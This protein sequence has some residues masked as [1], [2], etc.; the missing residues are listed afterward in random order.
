MGRT[1]VKRPHDSLPRKPRGTSAPAVADTEHLAVLE[2]L[3]LP[4]SLVNRRYTYTWVNT[5]YAGAH[6]KKPEEIIGRTARTLWGDT[7]DKTI[8]DKLDQC[9]AG[10]EARDEGWMHFPTF[11][12]RYCEV[13]YSPYRAP[14]KSV[15]SAIVITYDVTD[16]KELEERLKQREQLAIEQIFMQRD[17]ALRLAQLESFDE[18]LT[19]ILQTALKVAAMESGGIW[20]KKK[21]TGD[22]EL[23]S[24]I[25]PPEELALKSDRL[26]AGSAVWSLVMQGKSVYKPLARQGS[27]TYGAIIP[28]L[29]DG[30]V[31]GSLTM[32][33]PNRKE[34][35]EQGRLTLDFL[36]AE[37]GTIIARMQTRQQLEEEIVTR[38]QAECALEAE[39]LDLQE[40][41]AALRVLLKHREEDRKELE[42]RLVANV[43]QLV[44]PHVEKLKK[45][46][47][48]AS[49][50]TAVGFIEA[51]LKEILSPFLDN[52][53]AFNLTPRQLE[54]IGLIK[55]GRTTKDI[56]EMLHVTKEAI[57]K[58]RFLIRKKLNLNNEKTNLRSYLLSLV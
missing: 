43:K 48:E 38:R 42:S 2:A 30:Q 3:R 27:S 22:L 45:G 52:L 58:Q 40:A 5:R 9:F 11:G 1:S 25:S 35:P 16:R 8:K 13:V 32:A 50:V 7:F 24:S 49:H 31:I 15:S 18:G 26:P 28:I 54:I 33:S 46:R 36:S 41:N 44:L 14:G 4:V 12:R 6:G 10:K 37:L 53:R 23:I 39:H 21:P 51:N 56:A 29:R 57:D 19:I 34:V 47:L 17:L 55:V 20:L